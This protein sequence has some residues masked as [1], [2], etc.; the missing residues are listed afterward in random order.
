MYTTLELVRKIFAIRL[1]GAQ[2]LVAHLTLGFSMHLPGII[3]TDMK[4]L[5]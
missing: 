5:T 4:Q 1:V 3:Y 2:I